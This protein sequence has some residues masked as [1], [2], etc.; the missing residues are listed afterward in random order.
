MI[1]LEVAQSWVMFFFFLIYS[2]SVLNT[3]GHSIQVEREREIF[4]R[5]ECV[6]E[7]CWFR[8][9]SFNVIID[10]TRTKVCHVVSCFLFVL[11][12]FFSLV[13]LDWNCSFPCSCSLLE[14]ILESHFD[15]SIAFESIFLYS[16]FSGSSRYHIIRTQ[17]I[18][19]YHQFTSSS[20]V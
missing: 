12:L 2:T 8:A 5:E 4:C 18:N 20:E 1:F 16:F 14:H 11:S 7:I 9:F 19:R 17:F 10:N 13:V 15:L 3:E 6:S